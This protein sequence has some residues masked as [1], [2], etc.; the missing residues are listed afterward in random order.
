MS[1]AMRSPNYPAISLRDAVARTKQIYEKERNHPSDREVIA[2]AMG[3]SGVNG[4]SATIISSLLKYG[5]LEPSGGGYRVSRDALDLVL[6]RRGEPEYASVL[7]KAALTPALFNELHAEYGDELPSDHSL[8]ARLVKRDFT[9][10]A[11]DSVI[12]AYRDTIEFVDAEVG[13]FEERPDTEKE[14]EK[15]RENQQ[16][17]NVRPSLEYEE[18]PI[19]H[20][21]T[22]SY[23]KEYAFQIGP[24]CEARVMLRGEITQDALDTLAKFI[25]LTKVGFPKNAV[26][27]EPAGREPPLAEPRGQD[28][29]S[30]P[31]L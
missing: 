13:R 4:A 28:D 10:K 2:K 9:P 27:L 18:T 23:D 8:R 31:Q 11:A 3:Y 15:A 21:N 22:S 6:H 19:T 14:S 17:V 12:R 25:D 5:L 26:V 20:K 16:I 1:Q 29:I 24:N 30:P 7:R